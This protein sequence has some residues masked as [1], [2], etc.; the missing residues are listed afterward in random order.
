MGDEPLTGKASHHLQSAGFFEQVGGAGHDLK[1][2]M[3]AEQGHGSPVELDDGRVVLTDDQ[4][5]IASLRA[6]LLNIRAQNTRLHQHIHALE[7]RLRTCSNAGARKVGR[8]S[9]P[10]RRH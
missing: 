6:D 1:A 10:S 4:Q 3:A 8:P 9:T 5:S 2:G 7:K